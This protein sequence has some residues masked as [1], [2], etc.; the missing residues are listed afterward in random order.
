MVE[1]YSED[2]DCMAP[3]LNQTWENLDAFIANH[4]GWL[5]QNVKPEHSA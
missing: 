3:D 2:D 1:L 4:S 5:Q